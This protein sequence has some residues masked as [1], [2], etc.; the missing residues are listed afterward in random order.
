M[1]LLK[2]VF[3]L[4]EKGRPFECEVSGIGPEGANLEAI[5]AEGRNS[6]DSVVVDYDD[7]SGGEFSRQFIL[8][9]NADGSVVWTAGDIKQRGPI[10]EPT[11]VKGNLIELRRKMKLVKAR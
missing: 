8:H 5:L 1:T 7:S 3:P 6:C 2:T 11:P 4:L 9:S 10:E